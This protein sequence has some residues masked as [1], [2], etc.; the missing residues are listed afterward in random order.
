MSTFQILNPKTDW[1]T[2][3]LGFRELGYDGL[4]QDIFPPGWNGISAHA[5]SSLTLVT[6]TQVQILGY[7]N[8]T[9]GRRAAPCVFLIDGKEIGRIVHGGEKTEETALE[10]GSHK[11]E[12]RTED[13]GRAHTVWA[14]RFDSAEVPRKPFTAIPRN[15]RVEGP[16]GSEGGRVPVNTRGTIPQGA[17]RPTGGCVPCHKK[18]KPENV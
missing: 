2:V 4:P 15:R 9:A 7:L 6:E 8:S 18:G 3:V 17:L 13:I 12:V 16:R 14:F 10:P 5:C 11:L 1:G